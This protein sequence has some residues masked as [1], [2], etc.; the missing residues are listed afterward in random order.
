MTTLDQILSLKYKQ[1]VGLDNIQNISKNTTIFG[2][3][4]IGGSLFNSRQTILVGDVSILNN[5]YISGISTLVGDVTIG[6][7]LTILRNNLIQNNATIISN[8]YITNNSN[9][10][11]NL[12]IS[13]NSLFNYNVTIASSLN[14]SGNSIFQNGISVSN[15][16]SINNNPLN[17][18]GNIINIGNTNSVIQLLGNT[19]Y[20]GSSADIK[21][22]DKLISLNLNISTGSGIDNG[23]QSGIEILGTSGNGYIRTD[24]TATRFEIKPPIG[25]FGYIQTTDMNNNLFVSGITTIYN[26]VSILSS[27]NISSNTNINNSVTINNTLSIFGNSIFNNSTTINTNLFISSNTIIQNNITSNG[28]LNIIG[29]SLLNGYVTINSNLLVNGNTIFNNNANINSS[30]YVSSDTII[31]S[32]STVNGILY[33]SGN[34]L[35]QNN[36]IINNSLYISGNTILNNNITIASKL[37]VSNNTIIN[38]NITLNSNL[39]VSGSSII[40]GTVTIGSNLG[41]L[42]ILSQI[43]SILPEYSDNVSATGGGVPLWGFYRTGGVIKI[44]LQELTPYIYFSGT[45]TLTGYIGNTYTDPGAYALDTVGNTIQVYLISVIL[46]SDT[47]NLL[48]NI[49]LI[50]GTS[51]LVTLNSN[52]SIGTYILTYSTTDSLN[53]ISYNTRNF[54]ITN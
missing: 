42:N 33:I 30:L 2:N 51:T 14:I 28:N 36:N 9:I 35:F 11:N 49:K 19:N 12:N 44:R 20:I 38:G 10:G 37:L 25:I 29:N 17:I 22:A 32:N 6:N 48:S 21:V 1:I 18:Y 8:L 40:Q 34:S 7:N 41:Y 47:I 50:T 3:I 39:N 5:L 27:L 4:T 23:N 26:N 13:G 43:S 53:N 46:T 45:T 16:Q 52:L 54:I 31:Y 15:I 24:P